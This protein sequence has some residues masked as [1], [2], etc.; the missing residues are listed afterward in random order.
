VI[1]AQRRRWAQLIAPLR[2]DPIL[3]GLIR[4]AV[5]VSLQELEVD[6]LPEATAKLRTRRLRE[7]LAL[8]D[9]PAPIVE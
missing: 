4:G 5:W 2:A 6:D 1:P 7:L 9:Q 8:L 3:L